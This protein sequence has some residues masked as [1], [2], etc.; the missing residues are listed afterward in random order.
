MLL[1]AG[2]TGLKDSTVKPIGLRIVASTGVPLQDGTT[3]IAVKGTGAT[4]SSTVSI[5]LIQVTDSTTFPQTL[6]GKS[7]ADIIGN[8]TYSAVH[9]CLFP[10]G[11]VSCSAFYQVVDDSTNRKADSNRDLGSR[12]LECL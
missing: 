1:L 10:H 5:Y 12:F 6:L 2:C 4:P 3:L 11:K 9:D 8:F 7:N